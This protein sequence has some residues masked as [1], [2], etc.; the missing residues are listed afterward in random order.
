MVQN[1]RSYDF[2]KPSIGTLPWR[3][4]YQKTGD[5]KK[6]VSTVEKMDDYD[7]MIS[8]G[9]KLSKRHEAIPRT[10]RLNGARITRS[11]PGTTIP[12]IN[13]YRSRKQ[14]LTSFPND[15]EGIPKCR[16][17]CWVYQ[18]PKGW[19]YKTAKKSSSGPFFNPRD[20]LRR[21]GKKRS[22]LF[23]CQRPQINSLSGFMIFQAWQYFDC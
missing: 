4:E 13:I 10:C 1:L 3:E 18:I 5:F 14:F 20:R 11:T 21:V 7:M 15:W 12:Q 6:V 8:G 22:T 17:C 9:S 19:W 2:P 23:S 16:F